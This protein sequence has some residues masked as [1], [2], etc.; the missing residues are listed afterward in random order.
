V[1]LAG[2]QSVYRRGP[3]LQRAGPFAVLIV[4][5]AHRIPRDTFRTTYGQLISAMPQ[6][7]RIG[8]TATPYRLD[9]GLL[10]EGDDALFSDI[11]IQ[12]EA[13]ALVAEGWLA[14]LVGKGGDAEIKVAGVRVRAGDFVASDLAQVAEDEELVRRACAEIVRRG[15]DRRSW[16]LF[17]CGVAHAAM[18]RDE[19]HRLG[20][21]AGLVTGET[22]SDERAELLARFR[23]GRLRCMVNCEVLTTGFDAPCIDLI[24]LLR[25]TMSKGLYVQMLGRGMRLADGKSGCRIL[26]FA[27]NCRRHGDIDVLDA[28]EPSD[29]QLE[30]K[31][32]R[33]DAAAEFERQLAKHAGEADDFDGTAAE[34]VE[35]AVRAV[36]Y[37]L[38]ESRKVP[39]ARNLVVSYRTDREPVTIWLCPEY[40]TG[41]VFFARRWFAR[42][43]V[44][45]PAGAD[46]C[47]RVARSLPVPE[48]IAVKRDG[49]FWRVLVEHMPEAADAA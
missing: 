32:K 20:I 6:A 4:D 17:A 7:R 30:Q 15:A 1:I 31:R 45:M 40:R 44:T 29:D 28:F 16:L 24:G 25:P 8:L 35:L 23:A 47:L 48:R 10:T 33:D 37:S 42:R 18:L 2:V 46:A 9:S 34:V 27:G 22:P 39:G 26:D 43:G 21:D 5:E 3:E 12:V 19:M 38:A 41:A 11:L 14:P 13:K 36:L 49:G